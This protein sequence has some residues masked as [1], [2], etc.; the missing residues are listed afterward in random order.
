[1]LFPKKLKKQYTPEEF[2]ELAKQM[3][4]SAGT[5]EI[6]EPNGGD[7][8]LTTGY[9]VFAPYEDAH[10]AITLAVY[11]CK[12]RTVAYV[13]PEITDVSGL[14]TQIADN[15]VSNAIYR[16]GGVVGQIAAGVASGAYAAKKRAKQFKKKT[17]AELKEFLATFDK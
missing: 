8:I 2:V 1:M 13:K 16:T 7:S 15:M 17:D 12:F 6:I 5:P 4:W 9:I 3:T 10:F 11:N 14:A